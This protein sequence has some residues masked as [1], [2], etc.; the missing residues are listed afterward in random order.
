VVAF[1]ASAIAFALIRALGIR[2]AFVSS[3]LLVAT[4]CIVSLGVPG[5][6]SAVFLTGFLFPATACV[7]AGFAVCAPVCLAGITPTFA[8]SA[9]VPAGG[10]F[11]SRSVLVAL[12]GSVSFASAISAV[13]RIARRL[14]RIRF[15]CRVVAGS[16]LT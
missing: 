3:A 13:L 4:A 16:F 11:R 2:A 1:V 10:I 9:V 12:S 8:A 15:R 6:P 14:V 7:V 5:G